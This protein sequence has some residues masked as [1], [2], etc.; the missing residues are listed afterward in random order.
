MKF[1]KIKAIAIGCGILGVFLMVIFFDIATSQSKMTEGQMRT[2]IE[3]GG[4]VD[5]INRQAK[6]FFARYGTNDSLIVGRKELTDFPAFS[7]L[8]GHVALCT[9][10]GS[11]ACLVIPI[12]LHYQRTFVFIFS[13]GRAVDFQYASNSFDIASNI[14]VLK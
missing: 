12:G 5:E 6:I 4:G 14:R 10:S 8:S 3:R 7:S 11:S 13:L 9:N 1:L 2:T